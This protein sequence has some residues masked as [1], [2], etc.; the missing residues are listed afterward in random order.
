MQKRIFDIAIS[1][2]GL[3][4]I[5]PFLI[6][7]VLSSAIDTASWGVFIH[8]RIGKNAKSFKV[9]KIR[10]LHKRSGK[11]SFFGNF[12]KKHKLDELPQLINVLLGQM[13]MVGPRPDV[14]GYYDQLEGEA[15]RILDLKPGITS[16][17]ALKYYDENETLLNAEDPIAFNDE[18][19]FPDKVKMNLY[20]HNNNTILGD[21]KIIYQTIIRVILRNS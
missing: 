19:I 13:S 12:I 4:L 5:W 16:L 15:K 2:I 17:A 7:L 9:F 8:N 6:L 11:I 10:T 14:A 18:T 21:M 20:Y 1:L 3:L